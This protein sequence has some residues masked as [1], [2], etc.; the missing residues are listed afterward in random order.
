MAMDLLRNEKSYG[1]DWHRLVK[2]D[3]AGTMGG[4]NFWTDIY[5]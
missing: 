4:L 2:I 1:I 5:F 3:S